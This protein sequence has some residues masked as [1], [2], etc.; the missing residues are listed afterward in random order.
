MKTVIPN[1]EFDLIVKKPLS[2]L[3][4]RVEDLIESFDKEIENTKRNQR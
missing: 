1:R 3:D 2:G 4:V